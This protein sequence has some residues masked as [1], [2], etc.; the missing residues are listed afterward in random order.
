MPILKHCIVVDD[1]VYCWNQTRQMFTEASLVDKPDT[2]VPDH[3]KKT[4]HEEVVRQR[5]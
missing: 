3:I 1:K 5:G 2:N 4:Y